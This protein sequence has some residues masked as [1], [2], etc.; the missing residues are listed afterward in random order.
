MPVDSVTACYVLDICGARSW[1]FKYFDVIW[2]VL[3]I[4][5]NLKALTAGLPGLQSL[6]LS[7]CYNVSDAA[8]AQAL[9]GTLPLLTTLNLSLCKQI[10][11]N[12]LF[13]IADHLGYLHHVDV[14]GCGNITNKGILQITCKLKSLRTLNLRSCRNITDQGIAYVAGVGRISGSVAPLLE[15]LCLQD[16]QKITDS[17]L[18]YISQGLQMLHSLNLSF[19]ASITDAGLKFIA[20]MPALC[21]LNLCSC[22][23]VSDIGIGH[24][25]S[26]E[27]SRVTSLDVSFCEHIGDKTLDYIGN[28]SMRYCMLLLTV[29]VRVNQ[30]FFDVIINCC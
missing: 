13:R 3:S 23:N 21:E 9:S 4:R 22:D 1:K 2:Q 5:R 24:L 27:V 15:R 8:L 26:S 16:L 10:T 14:S 7:G 19:C 6:N 20:Q 30:G 18:K 17:A 25:A 12:S 28:G 11:D 29:V